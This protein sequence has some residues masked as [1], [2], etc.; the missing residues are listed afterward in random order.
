[1]IYTFISTERQSLA[2][3]HATQKGQK[4]SKLKRP[5]VVETSPLIIAFQRE[6]K[7]RS[8]VED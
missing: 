2:C 8:L 3:E 4:T 1:M 7:Q 6:Q 5:C